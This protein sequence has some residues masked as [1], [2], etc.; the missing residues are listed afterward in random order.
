MSLKLILLS[1]IARLV[2]YSAKQHSVDEAHSLLVC[3]PYWDQQEGVDEVWRSSVT[4]HDELIAVTD[5]GM[6][7][8]HP[9]LYPN[10][11]T[12][13]NENGRKCWNKFGGSVATTA[14]VAGISALILDAGRKR[15]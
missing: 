12:A 3:P 10:I 1:T 9:E 2:Q 14:K 15:I 8:H 11:I 13:F 4:G 5:I 7:V 6:D